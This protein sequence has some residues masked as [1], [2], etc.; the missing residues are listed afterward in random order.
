MG[1]DDVFFEL[2]D[3]FWT[4]KGQVNFFRLLVLHGLVDVLV[5]CFLEFVEHAIRLALARV[6]I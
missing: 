6:N 2:L 3:F 5:D 4:E 1:L